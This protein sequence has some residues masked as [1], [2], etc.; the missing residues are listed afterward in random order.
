[1]KDMVVRCF[2]KDHRDATELLT[3]KENQLYRE[4]MEAV[5]ART[6]ERI[7]ADFNRMPDFNIQSDEELS[8]LI[9]SA[10]DE[11]CGEARH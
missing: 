9:R 5:A 1:M 4:F 2:L 7:K 11:I 3:D 10:I 6:F 8:S